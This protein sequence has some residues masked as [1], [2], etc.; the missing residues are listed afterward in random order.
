MKEKKEKTPISVR[1][2]T[3]LTG[4]VF[5]EIKVKLRKRPTWKDR[6]VMSCG[7]IVLL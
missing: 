3:N 5:S 1:P 7:V 4:G 2:N 6:N